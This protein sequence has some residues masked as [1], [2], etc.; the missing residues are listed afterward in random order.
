MKILISAYASEPGC[1]SE[2]G[3]G[4]MVPT[5]MARKYPEHDIYVLTRSRC[6]EKIESALKDI[7]L[8]NLHFLFYDIPRYLFYK[9]EMKSNWGE[10]LNYL[11]WQLLVKKYVKKINNTYH[12]DVF[13]HLTFNQY[14]T[15]SPGFFLNISFV[16][17]PIG[18]AELIN[19]VF[20][21][22]LEQ[23]TLKKEN[24]RKSGKDLR[25]FGWWAKRKKNKKVILC[26]S[27][28]NLTRLEPYKGNAEMRMMPAIAFDPIDFDGIG[29]GREDGT[30]D[31]VFH[32]I[33]A[34]KA[35]DWK[36][37]HIFLKA[38]ALAYADDEKYKIT[39]VGIRFE[40][41]QKRVNG[42]I[43]E[44][45]LKNHVELVPF[46]Q[47]SD[48]LKMLSLCD[49]SVYPA[50]RDSGSMSV[51]EASALGCPSICFNAGGQDAFPDDTLVKIEIGETYD[52]TLQMFSNRL[53]WAFDNREELKRI[54]EF[55]RSW[56]TENLTWEKK[57]DDYIEIYKELIG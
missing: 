54:G 27:K 45:K 18:G 32:M 1:G 52:E 40:E 14:R 37:L 24:I 7:G 56:V 38:A 33:Y 15:P 43:S 26:S 30:K 17:G 23:H 31:D 50:F 55:S 42:W 5:K 39:L 10:Q 6:K 20:L 8:K 36:G 21:Q 49:L 46:I 3:V 29:K 22:D 53:R 34:G 19:D 2:Y 44:L 48:L 4:W 41:E 51:L 35:F 57:V 9:N 28:E 13:H 12:F 25:V 16:M 47:R 11:W